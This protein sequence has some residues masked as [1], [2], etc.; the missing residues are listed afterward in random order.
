MALEIQV[1]QLVVP[2]SPRLLSHR[3]VFTLILIV[4]VYKDP[5]TLVQ[6][7][8]V[9][10]TMQ[11]SVTD[12]KFS[13]LGKGPATSTASISYSWPNVNVPSCRQLR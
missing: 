8:C 9:C 13:L 5:E 1:P 4:A 10:V 6:W 7:V 2:L 12:I 3:N 11:S